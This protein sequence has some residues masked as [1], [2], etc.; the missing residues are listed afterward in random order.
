MKMQ[1]HS[2][3]RFVLGWFLY[4]EARVTD[5]DGGKIIVQAKASKSQRS[6][7]PAKKVTEN[8]EYEMR[9]CERQLYRHIVLVQ[10]IY[11]L[12]FMQQMFT[13]TVCE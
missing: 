7:H 4:Q 5:M 10:A 11:E 13:F 8:H 12:V 1:S 3:V 6:G 2:C 9:S